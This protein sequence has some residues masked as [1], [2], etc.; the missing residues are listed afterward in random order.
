[1]AMVG[2]S[3]RAPAAAAGAVADG[4]SPGAGAR[5]EYAA[6]LA[7][8]AAIEAD[9]TI[10][11]DA[12]PPDADGATLDE[13]VMTWRGLTWRRKPQPNRALDHATLGIL[14]AAWDAAD[15]SHER[16][17]LRRAR[18]QASRERR[19]D[20]DRRVRQRREDDDQ[21][22]S[23]GGSKQHVSARGATDPRSQASACGARASASGV[24]LEL[25][26][27]VRAR[28]RTRRPRRVVPAAHNCPS[29][30]RVA[31]TWPTRLRRR[32]PQTT[33]TRAPRAPCAYLGLPRSP[34]KKP[35]R[36]RG[37]KNTQEPPRGEPR[38][39]TTPLHVSRRRTFGSRRRWRPSRRA[40]R[41]AAC[42]RPSALRAFGVHPA[43]L[44]ACP[45][46]RA[47][48]R[49]VSITAVGAL[50][51]SKDGNGERQNEKEH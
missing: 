31:A 26:V 33:G 21:Q 9:I 17:Q 7:A 50:I 30:C 39:T 14:V 15:T 5:D 25:N 3:P 48:V 51:D 16:E 44:P 29:D 38:G 45:S 36:T 4:A 24:P 2:R 10:T 42:D 12:T 27:Q 8:R 47:S 49:K 40:Q 1:V 22:R 23:N 37:E 28:R 13:L 41:G 19:D 43:S 20:S 6:G 35:P 46:S 34:L 32:P 11:H 18:R